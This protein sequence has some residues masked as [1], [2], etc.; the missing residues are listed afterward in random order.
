MKQLNLFSYASDDSSNYL[1][2]DYILAN[3]NQQAYETIMNRCW[4]SMLL[5][6]NKGSGKSYLLNMWRSKHNAHNIR[7]GL[8]LNCTHFYI[9]DLDTCLTK[10]EEQILLLISNLSL[11]KKAKILIASSISIMNIDFQNIDLRLRLL[12]IQKV[13]LQNP[14]ENLRYVIIAKAFYI[15]K[16]RVDNKVIKF[17]DKR[18]G[19]C[20]RDVIRFIDYLVQDGSCQT[21]RTLTI[22]YVKKIL[23]YLD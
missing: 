17:L 4:H 13:T 19:G 14:S 11:N 16:L 1:E 12:S 2:E 8:E 3:T 20:Y 6:G 9:D 15:R 7:H 18:F 23:N 21:N 5:H 22:Q 10:E